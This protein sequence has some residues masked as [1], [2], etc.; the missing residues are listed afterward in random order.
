MGKNCSCLDSCE[1]TTYETDLSYA[2]FKGIPNTS[3]LHDQ[4]NQ[5]NTA[6]LQSKLSPAGILWREYLR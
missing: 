4:F 1:T 5:Y 3:S 2:Y 6:L